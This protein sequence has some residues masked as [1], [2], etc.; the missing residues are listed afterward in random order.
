MT[1]TQMLW[2]Q[3]ALHVVLVVGSAYIASNPKYVW[4]IPALQALGQG[5]PQPR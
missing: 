3:R 1:D 5:I 4:A 2:L